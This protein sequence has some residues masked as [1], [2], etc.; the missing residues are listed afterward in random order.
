M[1]AGAH[2]G[3]R[4]RGVQLGRR[5]QDHRVDVVAGE[6]LVEVGGGVGD[7]V[8]LR[9]FLRLFQL[10][11][12]DRGDLHSVDVAQ[13]VEVLD[14]EGA[15]AGDCDSHRCSHPFDRRLM[16]CTAVDGA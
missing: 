7:A 9:N 6:R 11:T 12:D 16:G 3:D 5:A 1:L 15:G 13:A 14:A 10:A 8:P 2:D 4:L